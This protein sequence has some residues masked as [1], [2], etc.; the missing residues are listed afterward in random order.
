MTSLSPT[1]K[2][3]LKKIKAQRN[4]LPLARVPMIQKEDVGKLVDLGLVDITTVESNG[5][6]AMRLVAADAVE[7]CS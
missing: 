4:G 5:R 3:L 1:Q 6:K 7:L 2:S